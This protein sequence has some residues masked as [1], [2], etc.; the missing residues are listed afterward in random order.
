MLDQ[1]I[2]SLIDKKFGRIE[3]SQETD[4]SKAFQGNL[5]KPCKVRGPTGPNGNASFK[6]ESRGLENLLLLPSRVQGR[7]KDPGILRLC[8]W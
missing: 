6:L 4:M 1:E 2:Q 8:E 5:V 7:V 3:G